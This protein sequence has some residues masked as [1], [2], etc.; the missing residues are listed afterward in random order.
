VCLLAT[1]T[2]ATWIDVDDLAAA[3]GCLTRVHTQPPG[4]QE[5]LPPADALL[6]APIT[7]NSINKW[8]TGISDNLALGVLNEML[9]TDVPTI[10]VPCAKALLRNHPAYIHSV[11]TLAD[12]GATVVDPEK[13]TR[14]NSDGL[15]T[16][17]W[18]QV[19]KALHEAT[20]PN[21]G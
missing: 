7:F 11:R 9:S 4:Q 17:D 19:R 3:T 20:T 18:A 15:A 1:P 10:I 21:T 13:V 6:A 8:A 16:F 5:S 2:A 12:M 14:K